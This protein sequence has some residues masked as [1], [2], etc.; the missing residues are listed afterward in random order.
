MQDGVA[1]HCFVL[2]CAE[3]EANRGPIA[4]GPS[5]RIEQPHIAVHL[6]DVLV[7]E[8]AKLEVDE[9][10][11]LQDDVVENEVDVEVFVL[12]RQ[13]LLSRHESKAPAKLEKKVRELAEYRALQVALSQQLALGEVKEIENE[14]VLDGVGWSFKHLPPGREV[15]DASLVATLEQA[16]EK[17]RVNLSL[18]VLD[19][20]GAS[21]SLDFV[22]ASFGLVFDL[23]EQPVM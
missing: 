3:D 12:E 2:L 1:G 21:F 20:P 7:C 14:G 22:E 4:F 23:H 8:L 10:V 11:A 13:P 9:Q 5:L 15:H 6:A 18:K 17:V 19:G 16:R